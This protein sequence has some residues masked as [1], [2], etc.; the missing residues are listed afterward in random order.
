VE[1]R[2][3]FEHAGKL[4][5]EELIALQDDPFTS[6]NAWY[7]KAMTLRD[8]S[9][10]TDDDRPSSYSVL[11]DLPAGFTVAGTGRAAEEKPAAGGRKTVQLEAEVVRGFAIYACK[12]L[13]EHRRT[14]RGLEL[15]ALLPEPAQD[16]PQPMIGLEHVPHA[17]EGLCR[18]RPPPGPPWPG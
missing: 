3:E 12:A 8:G 18:L 2:I 1:L 11:L 15:R 7:P 17:R 13:K 6:L 16:L 4:I 14:I 10:S 9:W 5:T